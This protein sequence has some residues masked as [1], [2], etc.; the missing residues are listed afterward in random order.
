MEQSQNVS[1]TNLQKLH[2]ILRE[3]FFVKPSI[4]I[5]ATNED[6]IIFPKRYHLRMT[7]GAKLYDLGTFKTFEDSL[8]AMKSIYTVLAMIRD[9]SP[10]L[11]GGC[12]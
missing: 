3:D 1:G 12:E 2:E 4:F 8:T 7:K 10:I 9:T 5:T 6:D 11:K